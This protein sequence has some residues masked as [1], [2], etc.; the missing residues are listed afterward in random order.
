MWVS[1]N[2]CLR[3]C[4]LFLLLRT[5]TITRHQVNKHP[6]QTCASVKSLRR[7]Y[8]VLV[9]TAN[10]AASVSMHLCSLETRLFRGHNTGLKQ[11]DSVQVLEPWCLLPLKWNSH[12]LKKTLYWQPSPEVSSVHSP[13]WKPCLKAMKA[14]ITFA[15]LPCRVN[16]PPDSCQT[17]MDNKAQSCSQLHHWL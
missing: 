13:I 11:W 4:H 7:H 10:W 2:E 3:T 15:R 14:G 16:G 12:F 1:Q 8:W 6:V 17:R 5:S 9:Q